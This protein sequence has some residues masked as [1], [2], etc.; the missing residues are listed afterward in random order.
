M[1][2]SSLKSSYLLTHDSESATS[3]PYQKSYV[4]RIY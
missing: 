3:F 4:F 2:V 1:S